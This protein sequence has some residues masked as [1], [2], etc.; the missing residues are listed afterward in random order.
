MPISE[1]IKCRTV[2]GTHVWLKEKQLQGAS[3]DVLRVSQAYDWAVSQLYFCTIVVS[4][5][6]RDATEVVKLDES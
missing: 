4:L 3:W 6:D 1:W 2:S 5:E